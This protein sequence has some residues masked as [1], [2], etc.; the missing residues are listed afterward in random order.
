[1]L[2]LHINFSNNLSISE[3]MPFLPQ[4]NTISVILTVRIHTLYNSSGNSPPKT[5][6]DAGKVNFLNSSA[7]Q[8]PILEK[9]SRILPTFNSVNMYIGIHY[10]YDYIHMMHTYLLSKAFPAI[11]FVIQRPSISQVHC[12]TANGD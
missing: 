11:F 9:L 4:Q 3:V 2:C 1:M 12:N 6:S 10:N 8:N 5:H 7:F